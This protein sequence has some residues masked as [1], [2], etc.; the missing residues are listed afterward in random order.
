MLDEIGANAGKRVVAISETAKRV[1]ASIGEDR[2]GPVGLQMSGRH[3][4]QIGSH[5]RCALKGSGRDGFTAAGKILPPGPGA[6]PQAPRPAPRSRRRAAGE[7]PDCWPEIYA[8]NG[9]TPHR[10]I[11]PRPTGAIGSVFLPLRLGRE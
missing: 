1:M 10:P 6:A 7:P 2:S 3:Q 4:T 11:L 8:V 5:A 9:A